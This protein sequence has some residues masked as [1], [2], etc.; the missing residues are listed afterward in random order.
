MCL[1][2]ILTVAQVRGGQR[3][4]WQWTS[5]D[6]H[7]QLVH[8]STSQRSL[9]WYTVPWYKHDACES[10]THTHTHKHTHT[11]TNNV[12]THSEQTQSWTLSVLAGCD[13]LAFIAAFSRSLHLFLTLQTNCWQTLFNAALNVAPLSTE[14]RSF[15]KNRFLNRY[16]TY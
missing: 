4:V 10:K 15:K 16:K 2:L 14:N 5:P 1:F 8:S 13:T 6:T 12:K 9:Q 3:S 7:V 11:H